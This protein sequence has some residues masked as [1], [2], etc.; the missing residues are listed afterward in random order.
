MTMPIDLVLVRH[1]Q[2]EGN[3]ANKRSRAGDHSAFTS[4]FKDRIGAM[5]R[6]TDKGREQAAAA[7]EWIR[8]NISERFDRYYVSEY[9]RAKETAA[10][11]QLSG[12]SWFRDFYL[13]ER[14]WGELDM[15]A[16]NERRVQFAESLRRR[17]ID[18]LFWTPPNGES[19]AQL[20]LRIDRI[21]ETL[22]RECSDRRVIIVC[23]GEVML[24]FRIRLERMSHTGFR[25]IDTSDHPHDKI[26]NCQVL[27]YTRQHPELKTIAPFCNWMRSVCPTDLSLSSNDWQEI[28]RQRFSNTD[29]LAEAEKMPRLIS[30]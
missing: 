11:L 6:L 10:L 24:A 7:G 26:H 4:E 15:M 16:D 14:E 20:C 30:A 8:A 27:H 18:G 12:A 3:V 28:K 29:L 22:H 2:S 17:E 1:G 21:L 5:W 19:L 13:R 25:E 23:H 9:V